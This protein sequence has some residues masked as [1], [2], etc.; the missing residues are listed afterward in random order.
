MDEKITSKAIEII[1]DLKKD[2]Y[3]DQVIII[4]EVAKILINVRD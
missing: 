1:Q 3:D 2:F 4:L